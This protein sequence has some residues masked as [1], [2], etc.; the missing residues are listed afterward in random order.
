MTS[1]TNV[2]LLYRMQHTNP[3][4]AMPEFGRSTVHDEGV[5]LIA[6]WIASFRGIS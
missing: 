2:I 6:D 1:N 5:Q 4:I 3:A